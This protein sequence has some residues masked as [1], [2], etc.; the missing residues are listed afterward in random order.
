MCPSGFIYLPF[1]KR[2][3]IINTK[4]VGLGQKHTTPD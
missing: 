2:D 4:H 3:C 1:F